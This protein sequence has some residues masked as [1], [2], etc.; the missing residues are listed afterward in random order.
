MVQ[1]RWRAAIHAGGAYSALYAPIA[2]LSGGDWKEGK[3]GKAGES[4]GWKEIRTSKVWKGG[5]GVETGERT[6]VPP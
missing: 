6:G 4:K 3:R 2:G 5:G 1:M